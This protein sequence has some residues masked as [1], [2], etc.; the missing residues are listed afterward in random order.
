MSVARVIEIS[1]TSNQSRG[2]AQAG[3]TRANKTLRNVK[4]AWVKE[5]RVNVDGGNI[6]SYQV[7]IVAVT[8]VCW[9]TPRRST[10]A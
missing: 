6:T 10:S 3:I 7:N 4:S 5:Q 8:F 1:A 9:T 2:R